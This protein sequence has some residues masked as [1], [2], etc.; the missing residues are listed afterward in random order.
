MF[1]VVLSDPSILKTSFNAISSIVG[2]VQIRADKEGLTLDA[3]DKSHISFVHLE[4]K[5]ELFDVYQSDEHMKLNVDTEEL[6]HVLKRAGK[7]DTIELSS[8]GE[9]LTLI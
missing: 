5:P 3:L 6:I 1:K 2:E 9:D 7:D 8:E 4:L